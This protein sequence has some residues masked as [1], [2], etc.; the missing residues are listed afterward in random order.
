[1]FTKN[2]FMYTSIYLNWILGLV[3]TM[4][5]HWKNS[6]KWWCFKEWIQALPI[7]CV[8]EPLR[9]CGMSYYPFQF[10]KRT[11]KHKLQVSYPTLTHKKW[12]KF[13]LALVSTKIFISTKKWFIGFQIKNIFFRRRQKRNKHYH[14][15][16]RWNSTYFSG[17]W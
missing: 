10:P 15:S 2:F 3:F 14:K 9:R 8:T 11:W 12:V 16:F 4:E 5:R 13:V 6:K 7:P 1:M 17:R